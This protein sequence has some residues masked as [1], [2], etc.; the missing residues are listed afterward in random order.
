MVTARMMWLAWVA[1]L[2]A[3]QTF[4]GETPG[5]AQQPAS[6]TRT[7]LAARQELRN[8]ASQ[9]E[10]AR[11]ARL[12]EIVR[13]I[14]KAFPVEWDWALQDSRGAVD[15]L[16]DDPNSPAWERQMVTRVLVEIGDSGEALRSAYKSLSPGADAGRLWEIY[17][18]ACQIRRSN[19]LEL[20]RRRAPQIV[21]TKR[22]TIRP[23]FFA[24]TEGQSDAQNERH[25]E[26]GSALCLWSAGTGATRELLSDPHGVIRDPCVSWD[27]RRVVFA[28]KKSLN[29]DDYHLYELTLA[30]G[31]VRQ[32]TSGA[33][34]AD[35]EPAYLPDGGIVFTSSRC[36]QTVDCWW[37]E[38]SNLYIC[39]ADGRY[40]RRVG[41]DQVH[42]VYPQ[43]LEDGRVIYTRW[44]YNDRSQMWPQGLFQMNPDG[45]G[46][47]E[48]Y[49]NNS[50]FPTTIAHARG[51]PGTGK[52]IGIFTGHH[53]AQTG[54][55]GIIDPSKG[56]QENTGAQL[57]APVRATPAERE[58]GYGQGGEL[59]QYP[60]PLSEDEFLVTYAPLGWQPADEGKGG[61][62]F[63]IY[64]MDAHGRRELLATDARLAC[65]QPSP[66]LAR[67]PPPARPDGVD[68]R[69]TTGTY[70][71]QDIY[72]GP[73]LRGVPRGTVKKLRVV[74][75]GFRPAGIGSNENGGPGGGA[76]VCT[77]I[78]IGNGAWD[79][80]TVLGDATV[81]EDGSA[82]FT[83]P[84]R[85]P[86]YFLALDARNH[87]VQTMRSWSTLQPG[88]N[89]SCVGCHESKNT[90]PLARPSGST[91]ALKAGPQTLTPFYGQP[92]GFSFAREIQP[93]LDRHCIR[94]HRNRSQRPPGRHLPNALTLESD[95]PWK[96][97]PPLLGWPGL[98]KPRSD[99]SRHSSGEFT[100]RPAFS[101]LAETTLDTNAKRLWSDAYLNLTLA[102]PLNSFTANGARTGV[103]DG[104]M[105]NWIGA[106]SVP[107]P[108]PPCLAGACQSEIFLLLENGHYGVTLSSEE[109][110]KLAC[111]IDLYVPYC[112]DYEE[113]NA[114]NAE[115]TQKFR[116]FAEKRKQMEDIEAANIRAWMAAQASKSAVE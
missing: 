28:W 1:A 112:G 45:T 33:G 69:Q 13:E 91:L 78:A 20:V 58:D 50:W 90:T 63:G 25:F 8:A 100:N 97:R 36:V 62:D 30:T 88:E 49:K 76:L 103:F 10:A 15:Q 86:V 95:P 52:V 54:K 84:A 106:Q 42:T 64:W 102:K 22:R 3:A 60:F 57:I 14:R 114:W 40:L 5:V 21:F 37:T 75:L 68:Y 44:D 104:R 47:T 17:L 116:H 27:A 35:Y 38:V 87:A 93:I 7:L 83:V 16:L 23:S 32:L 51:I 71:I 4:G 6:W 111:W 59:F 9:S 74:A 105:V 113:S 24:Y 108:L 19:R 101:L 94:C 73:G 55:L 89:Q 67:T 80:K 99:T 110:D 81:Q 56:R 96:V 98:E 70:Y 12:A 65:Q 11:T 79:V 34:F 2:A 66:V 39:D 43:V 82:F 72:A 41:F 92:R 115:E 48:F 77:P 61:A 29:D 26:P 109:R 46:Q 107:T 31:A 85:T 53:T 18:Q